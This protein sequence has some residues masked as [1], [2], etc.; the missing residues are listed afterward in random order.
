MSAIIICGLMTE[1]TDNKKPT[2]NGNI[3]EAANAKMVNIGGE[4]GDT[5][6]EREK[7]ATKVRKAK[8]EERKRAKEIQKQNKKKQKGK[9]KQ[10]KEESKGFKML[11]Q[12]VLAGPRIGVFVMYLLECLNVN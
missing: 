2:E 11:K 4:D 3:I 1:T 9:G 6:K 12:A 8:K 10:E 5:T 7:V